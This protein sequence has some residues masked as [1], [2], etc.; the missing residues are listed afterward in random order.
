MTP[1]CGSWS[2]RAYGYGVIQD[3]L[4]ERITDGI[5]SGALPE[6]SASLLRLF[7]AEMGLRTNTINFEI[8][9]VRAVTWTDDNEDI[10]AFGIDHVMRQS[11]ALGGGSTEM[12]RNVISERLLGMPREAAFDR[13]RPFREVRTNASR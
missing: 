5:R 9:G 10:G 6:S 8:A 1:G 13:D 12:A 3:Q 2:A 11:N 7:R 4:I